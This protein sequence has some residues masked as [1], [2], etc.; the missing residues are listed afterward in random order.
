MFINIVIEIRR[1]DRLSGERR[2]VK[3]YW[4]NLNLSFSKTTF[5]RV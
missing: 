4:N 5:L 2:P 1:N 3:K